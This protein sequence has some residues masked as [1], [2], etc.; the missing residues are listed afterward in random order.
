MIISRTPLRVSFFGG[1]TDYPH[2]FNEH[3]GAVLATAIDKYIYISTR[4]LP[5]F[6]DHKTRIVWSFI[7]RIKEIDEIKHPS[8]RECLRFMNINDGV[9]IHYDADLPARTGLGSS[10]TFT[11]GLLNSLYALKGQM[12]PK[13]LLA[14]N[15]IS[16]E[17]DFI[18]ENVGCQDQILAA[19]GGFN[20]VKFKP[21]RE[22]E[23]HPITL[24][25]GRMDMFQKHLMLIFTGFTR[26]ASEVAGELIKK[27]PDKKTELTTMHQIVYEAINILN[28]NTDIREFGK[29]LNKTWELKRSL[30]NRITTPEIDEIY[31]TA[32]KAG[33]LG[34]KLLGAGG[35]GF[36]LLFAEPEAQAK[37]KQK[38]R[39]F[40]HV[41]FQFETM[42]SQIIFYHPETVY[43]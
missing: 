4:A 26:T 1:G 19:F 5:P 37:I 41:P 9:E 12:V 15:A 27:T 28:S 10:S 20:L 17:Q 22:F 35:G 34:G 8:A 39:K 25:A 31:S 23:V 11:V 14:K 40:L 2:W 33:A 30:T 32:M 38:L 24:D 6:F 21:G 18:K 36:M 3:E 29:L 16:V 7:E 13:T 42:G 43:E